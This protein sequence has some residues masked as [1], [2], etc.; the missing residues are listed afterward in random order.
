ML[1]IHQHHVMFFCCNG[2]AAP[3]PDLAAQDWLYAGKKRVIGHS[4]QVDMDA[5]ASETDVLVLTQVHAAF[6]LMLLLVEQHLG[7]EPS[8]HR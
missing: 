8:W 6:V 1:A 7:H 3:T 5:I 4:M 2:G